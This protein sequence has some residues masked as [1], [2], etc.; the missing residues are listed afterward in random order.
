MDRRRQAQ[1]AGVPRTAPRQVA[2]RMPLGRAGALVLERRDLR[3][4]AVL[5]RLA[6]ILVLLLFKTLLGLVRAARGRL[7]FLVVGR[8]LLIHGPKRRK[9]RAPVALARAVRRLGA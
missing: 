5:V 2:A 7:A 1:A 3:L 8:S 9:S 4:D 6:A